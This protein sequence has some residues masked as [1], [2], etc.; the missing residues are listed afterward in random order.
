MPSKAEIEAE[1]SAI[2]EKHITPG[3]LVRFESTPAANGRQVTREGKVTAVDV[4]LESPH[5]CP[6][7]VYEAMNKVNDKREREGGRALERGWSLSQPALISFRFSLTP[8]FLSLS[9]SSLLSSSNKDGETK[10][11]KNRPSKLSVIKHYT[12]HH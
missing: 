5:G 9:L 4:E 1:L 10:E 2:K 7:V 11:Y 3:K 12:A 8:R 6:M